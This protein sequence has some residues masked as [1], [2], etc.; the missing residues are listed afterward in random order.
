MLSAIGTFSTG[1]MPLLRLRNPG[2]RER[3]CFNCFR[4]MDGCEGNEHMICDSWAVVP[5]RLTVSQAL[6]Y[7]VLQGGISVSR[8]TLLRWCR[9]Y[10]LGRRLGP[11]RFIVYTQK[12][13]D[14]IDAE[15]N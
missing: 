6:G 7:I 3:N 13:K 9:D 8:P 5:D 1:D 4:P 12:L 2:G 14:Y 10:K 11:K 15:D